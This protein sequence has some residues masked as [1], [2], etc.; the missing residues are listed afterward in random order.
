MVLGGGKGRQRGGDLAC[1]LCSNGGR[2]P[3]MTSHECWACA[4]QTAGGDLTWCWAAA[5]EDGATATSRACWAADRQRDGDLAWCW[6]EDNAAATSPAYSAV[7]G[8]KTTRL[9]GTR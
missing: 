4:G 1:V 3:A 9:G 8:G 5:G 2:Q 7:A 6:G